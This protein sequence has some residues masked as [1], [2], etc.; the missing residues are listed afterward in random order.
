[1]SYLR[2]KQQSETYRYSSTILSEKLLLGRSNQKKFNNSLKR[3]KNR[4]LYLLK[5][6]PECLVQGMEKKKKKKGGHT[7]S[8][9]N[10]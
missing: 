7:A 6:L 9:G 1:M 2:I 3:R 4:T 5:N 8:V 10:G